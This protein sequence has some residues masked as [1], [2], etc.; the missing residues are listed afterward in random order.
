MDVIGF[1]VQTQCRP[2]RTPQSFVSLAGPRPRRNPVMRLASL[3]AL[4]FGV[5]AA[6]AADLTRLDRTIKKEPVYRSK[7]PKYGLLVFGPKAES[8]VWLVLDLAGE[9]ADPDGS[10][11]TLYVDRNG[12][13]DLTAADETVA[14]S[15]KT[16]GLV[17]SFSREPD[18]TFSPHFEAGD[19]PIRDGTAGHTGLTIDVGAYIQ[20][21]R[22]VS[23]SVKANGT[24]DQFAGGPLLAFADRPQEAPVI[25]FAGPLTMRV[26][27][28]NG[29]LHVPINYADKA[30]ADT[31]YAE[32]PPWYEQSPLVGGE[33]RMLAAQIGTPGLGRGTFATLSAGI[34]PAALHPV[35]E[36]RFPTADPK[37]APIRMKVDLDKRC[38]GTLFRGGVQAPAGAATGKATVTLSYP[39]W[40]VGAVLVGTGTV[41]VTN[42]VKPAAG[43]GTK[44]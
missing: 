36:I 43:D 30:D 16:H 37:A 9:P 11:N 26:A 4:A 5:A 42:P 18:V 12:D 3:I 20:R 25:H 28:E 23:V 32:H 27:M 7:S 22:P 2:E 6:P 15:M 38:C 44:E 24:D 13:G 34:P 41:E 35:A 31:W 19:I 14:C 8:R 10:K 29:R 1:L 33:S 39:A 17:S 21:H 40:K